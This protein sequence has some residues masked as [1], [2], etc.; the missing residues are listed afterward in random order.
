MGSS[1]VAKRQKLNQVRAGRTESL[2]GDQRG[3]E[4]NNNNNKI[5]LKEEITLSENRTNSD[6]SRIKQRT[7]ARIGNYMKA[8]NVSK[9]NCQVCGETATEIHHPDY[10]KEREINFLC[11]KC[12]NDITY[13]RIICPDPMILELLSIGD[14]GR[15]LKEAKRQR[16]NIV[17]DSKIMTRL[18][19]Y[20]AKT[21]IPMSRIMDEVLVRYL[22]EKEL[23][24]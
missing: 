14:S 8:N 20:S 10:T 12:H 24:D 9:G 6:E 7:R 19:K 16:V 15:E 5:A 2:E 21:N 13:S 23:K 4:N 3:A 1:E 18:R 17:V 22:D 11:H